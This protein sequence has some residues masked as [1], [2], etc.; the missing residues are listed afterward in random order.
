MNRCLALWTFASLAFSCYLV[1][2]GIIWF[3]VVVLATSFISCTLLVGINLKDQ[4]DGQ[5]GE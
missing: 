5:G 1:H 4:H 2:I 3:S